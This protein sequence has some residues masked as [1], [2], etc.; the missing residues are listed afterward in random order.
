MALNFGLFEDGTFAAPS[1]QEGKA[2]REGDVAAASGKD[3]ALAVR[4]K[5]GEPTVCP[6]KTFTG[7]KTTGKYWRN[8][9]FV[10]RK[11]SLWPKRE[12]ATLTKAWV[13]VAELSEEAKAQL[14]EQAEVTRQAAAIVA[15]A[16]IKAAIM[17]KQK[18]KAAAKKAA[19]KEYEQPKIWQAA[20]SSWWQQVGS[21]AAAWGIYYKIK[22]VIDAA[23]AAVVKPSTVITPPAAK[24]AMAEIESKPVRLG[25]KGRKA[26]AR[27]APWDRQQASR[28]ANKLRGGRTAK[29]AAA[30]L[31]T[32]GKR[33]ARAVTLA[34]RA[35]QKAA[36]EQ[37]ATDA[38][39][40]NARRQLLE[41]ARLRRVARITRELE[42]AGIKLMELRR[43]H[44]AA[45]AKVKDFNDREMAKRVRGIQMAW[46]IRR[47]MEL[48]ARAERFKATALKDAVRG[49]QATRKAARHARR[50]GLCKTSEGARQ[51]Q[52]QRVGPNANPNSNPNPK[53][54]MSPPSSLAIDGLPPSI[55]APRSN[56]SMSPR[57]SIDGLPPSVAPR[58]S[59]SSLLDRAR[60]DALLKTAL[61]NRGHLASRRGEE[62]LTT[63]I[64]L[65][66][67]VGFPPPK[68]GWAT[69]N[70]SRLMSQTPTGRAMA[71]IS[72]RTTVPPCSSGPRTTVP[73]CSSGPRTTVPP[74]SCGPRTT[75][76]PC[77][78]GPQCTT[79]PLCTTVPPCT[80]PLIFVDLAAIT[81]T[82]AA[83]S[84]LIF[85]DLAA[86][87]KTAAA[88]S[89]LEFVDLAA[90]TKTAASPSRVSLEHCEPVSAMDQQIAIRRRSL[91][92]SSEQNRF[93]LSLPDIPWNMEL[94]F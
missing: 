56:K 90:I 10:A 19:R 8:H 91:P 34:E 50:C 51:G 88:S 4:G 21:H 52:D 40:A 70:I 37:E 74:C 87:T 58:A 6:Q 63:A 89:T 83:P 36:S 55:D 67:R 39:A 49:R 13:E 57:S 44:D 30:N 75:V 7:E 69:A 60:T 77:S 35:A 78:S 22:A 20:D 15:R 54:S 73:P 33:K 53:Q 23:N 32:G 82:A 85:V 1:G 45:K 43:E 48:K 46:K 80:P 65:T 94:A 76:P 2:S 5:L 86:I 26:K 17:F 31:C 79:V 84:T 18:A 28:R 64:F 42:E 66:G 24:T 62:T 41:Q 12:V 29:K 92:S 9:K 25:V 3:T 93:A 16:A 59:L 71:L 68:Y 27:R 14:A 61:L 47:D 81:K 11:V 38:K 72:P